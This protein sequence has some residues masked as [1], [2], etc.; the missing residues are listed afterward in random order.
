MKE[1]CQVC[2]SN[3]ILEGHHINFKGMGGSSRDEIHDPD[4]AITL[5][6]DCHNQAHGIKQPRLTKEQLREAKREDEVRGMD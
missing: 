4:N 6:R 2:R 1:Y 3:N 5:C